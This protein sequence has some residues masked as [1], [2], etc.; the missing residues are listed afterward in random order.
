[1]VSPARAQPLGDLRRLLR[2]VAAQ[3]GAIGGK[4]ARQ[5]AL[6]DLPVAL[7]PVLRED[8]VLGVVQDAL[9]PQVVNHGGG[10]FSEALRRDAE[11]MSVLLDPGQGRIE[12]FVL[13]LHPPP[14]FEAKRLPGRERHLAQYLETKV[15]A[16]LLCVASPGALAARD[17]PDLGDQRA[18]KGLVGFQQIIEPRHQIAH[19]ARIGPDAFRH[20]CPQA[21]AARVVLHPARLERRVLAVV[22]EDEQA[23][24][25]RVVDHVLGEDVHVRDVDRPYRARRFAVVGARAVADGAARE[26]ARQR[27]PGWDS[28]RSAEPRTTGR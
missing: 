10:A 22:A 5:I 15:L 12:P 6:L 21:E 17:L 3:L 26:A 18:G 9:A 23:A 13:D 7:H 8:L 25:L 28:W 27:S 24:A 2:C 14:R 19:R 4:E 16:A 11:P 1:M 20:Q